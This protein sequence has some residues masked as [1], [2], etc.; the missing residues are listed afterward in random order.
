M[1][2]FKNA[3]IGVAI[4]QAWKYLTKKDEMGRTK[5]DEIKEKAPEWIEKAKSL[6]DDVTSKRTF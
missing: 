4:Y 3:I 5:I 6:R 1:G 2:F